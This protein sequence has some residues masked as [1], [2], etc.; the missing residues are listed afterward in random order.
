MKRALVV[1]GGAIADLGLLR[2]VA[3]V[4]N[5]IIAANGGFRFLAKAGIR[6][7]LVVGDLDSLSKSERDSLAGQA[8][9]T[10]LHPRHKDKTD[11]ELA[12][13]AAIEEGA[14]RILCFGMLGKR[15]DQTLANVLL[16]SRDFGKR[17]QICFLDSG[18]EVFSVRSKMEWRGT[19]GER[20]SIIPLTPVVSGVTLKGLLYGLSGETLHQGS[21]R[22]ISNILV[23]RRGSVAVEQGILLVLRDWRR[24]SKLSA[25]SSQLSAIG[26][27]RLRESGS[28]TR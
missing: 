21:T 26:A 20:V 22:G 1:A 14:L 24:V 7:S 25:F 6:P 10:R 3:G 27:G 8:I 9:Q 4:S 17:A 23:A 12:L 2:S 19:P 28:R 5:L 18:R 16:L 15:L 11:A 13:E